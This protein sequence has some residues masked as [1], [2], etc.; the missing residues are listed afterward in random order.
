MKYRLQRIVGSRQ[1]D[2]QRGGP[3]QDL[4]ALE[5][6]A[7]GTASQLLH[8]QVRR[9]P[10]GARVCSSK[11]LW[12]SPCATACVPHFEEQ[13]IA[14]SHPSANTLTPT[15]TLTPAPRGPGPPDLGAQ[16]G[17]EL[18]ARP[19]FFITACSFQVLS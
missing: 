9:A 15:P 7:D 12:A 1:S 4:Q 8:L 16:R 2:L 19:R 18:E 3:P 11:E 10:L 13:Q 14:S 17:P 6:Y 5:E